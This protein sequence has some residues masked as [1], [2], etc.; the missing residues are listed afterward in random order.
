MNDVT[1]LVRGIWSEDARIPAPA[2]SLV[3]LTASVATLERPGSVATPALI[4][5]SLVF[6]SAIANWFGAEAQP[7][8]APQTRMLQSVG[9]IAHLVETSPAAPGFSGSLE[10]AIS[11]LQGA[12][13]ERSHHD[14]VDVA[15][16]IADQLVIAKKDSSSIPPYVP[17]LSPVLESFAATAGATACTFAPAARMWGAPVWLPS[18][19]LDFN[20]DA[21][22]APLLQFTK[23]FR[24]E[25][26]DAFIIQPRLRQSPTSVE[27]VGRL[28]RNVLRALSAV[29]PSEKRPMDDIVASP[30][31]QFSFNDEPL[32]VMAMSDV[33]PPGHVRHAPEGTF[34]MLQPP[35]SF[36]AHGIGHGQ[37]KSRELK[38]SVRTAFAAQGAHYPSEL[39]DRR[40]ET[41][42]Y[43]LP[44]DGE[45]TVAWWEPD[46]VNNQPVL[47]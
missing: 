8:R 34:F 42:L 23:D 18:R 43:L 5:D 31:W 1:A 47:F 20:I 14:G 46:V 17:S 27:D 33:Y 19:S 21:M 15:T 28:L 4:G 3:R 16:A 24:A 22:R 26:L 7:M 9:E 2:R 45:P 40:I 39:I 37:P 10:L 36:S 25:R 13:L 41:L 30:G 44:L 35:D 32:F 6:S 38:Q 11:G 29:D 12:L